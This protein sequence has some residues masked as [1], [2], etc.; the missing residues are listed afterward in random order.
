MEDI[1]N[2][3]DKT[4]C[5]LGNHSFLCSFRYKLF[6]RENSG[7]NSGTGISLLGR[8]VVSMHCV[9]CSSAEILEEISEALK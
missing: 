2:E 9:V 5:F 7:R 8:T 6:Y 3:E 4:N 1:N